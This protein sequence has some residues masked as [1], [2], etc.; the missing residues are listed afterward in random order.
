L[1]GNGRWAQKRGLPRTAGHAA[2]AE[3]FRKIA[4]YCKEIGLDY[5]TVYAF[6]TENWKRSA[7]EVGGIMNILRDY[8]IDSANFKGENIRLHFVGDLT[9]IDADIIE[10]IEKAE[11]DSAEAT[12]LWVNIALNYGGRDEI[13]H[14]VKDITNLALN[15]EL[16][17]NDI[18]EQTISDHLYTAGMPD[19]DLLI[20]PGGEYRLSNY[21][22]WQSAYS[23]IYIDDVL[24]PDYTP[25]DL[26]RAIEEYS[27]RNRRF[28][29][30]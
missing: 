19:P 30:V 14:A 2:G 26:D 5:L 27:R 6:S 4:T 18:T 24:W 10:L 29:G 17:P 3:T 21:L 9:P 25:A 28:G 16:T 1:D 12:G 15:G 13:L 11:A 20:R 7:E 23:E 22:L 8:L